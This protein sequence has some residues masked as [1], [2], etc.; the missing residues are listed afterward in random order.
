MLGTKWTTAM[1]KTTINRCRAGDLDVAVCS[2]PSAKNGTNLQ[3]MSAMISMGWISRY[4]DEVQCKGTTR[5]YFLD[6]LIQDEFVG[7]GN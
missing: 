3:G 4:M 1:Q 2:V 6:K 7:L 5:F